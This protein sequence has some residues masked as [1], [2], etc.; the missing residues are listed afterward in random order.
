MSLVENIVDNIMSKYGIERQDIE[1]AKKMIDK[2]KFTKRN[3]D[4][5]MIIDIGDGIEL[6]IKQDKR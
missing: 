3:G 6:S 1:K 4:N 5:Y 2:I